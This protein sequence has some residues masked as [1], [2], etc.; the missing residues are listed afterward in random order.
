[1]TAEFQSAHRED[2]G[3]LAPTLAALPGD[4][5]LAIDRLAELGYRRIQLSA[6]QVGLRPREMDRS[7]R[8]GLLATLQRREM[9]PAGLDAWVPA[10]RLTDPAHADR[11]LAALLE[12]VELAADMGRIPVCVNLPREDAESDDESDDGDSAGVLSIREL[13]GVLHDRAAHLGVTLANHRVPREGETEG[14]GAARDPDD[15]RGLGVDPPAWLAADR[16]PV[17]AVTMAGSALASV[18]LVD[19][20]TTGMRG[21][22]GDRSEGQLDLTAYRVALSVAGYEGP[23]VVDARQWVD[24]WAGLAQSAEAWR[25]ATPVG[26]P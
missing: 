7:A 5:R 17:D 16:D 10:R 21:P 1:M 9:A 14:W 20:L 8:R 11:A 22:V 26:M 6:T 24:P 19:L 12:A 4:P 25:S 13:L 3:P 23:V 18:R 15:P 2:R